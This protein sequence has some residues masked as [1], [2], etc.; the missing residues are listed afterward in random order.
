MSKPTQEQINYILNE[1]TSR[2]SRGGSMQPGKNY[3]Q[4][5]QAAIAWME[6]YAED[7]TNPLD[8]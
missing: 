2:I 3:E 7:G 1:C 5:V 8:D 4:G 6:G